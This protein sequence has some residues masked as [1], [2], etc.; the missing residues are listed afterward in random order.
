MCIRHALS[1]RLKKQLNLGGKYRL[2]VIVSGH[3]VYK[4]SLQ[5][6]FHIIPKNKYNPKSIVSPIDKLQSQEKQLKLKKKK[7]EDRIKPIY[8]RCGEIDGKIPL[9]NKF[10]NK[11]GAKIGN[12]QFL[13]YKPQRKT[14]KYEYD[15]VNDRISKNN[16][17]YKL[18]TSKSNSNVNVEEED[19]KKQDIINDSSKTNFKVER[20]EEYFQFHNNDNCDQ[21]KV[22]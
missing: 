8:S 18:F 9:L 22:E 12:L 11:N 19:E 6:L 2:P 10:L 16:D 21:S 5:R 1:D 17:L 20:Q 3:N 13:L 4:E 7:I 14:I 15:S